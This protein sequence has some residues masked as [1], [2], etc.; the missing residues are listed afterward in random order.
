MRHDFDRGVSQRT[1]VNLDGQLMTIVEFQ[2]VKPGKG[3]A[4][5][6]TKFKNVLTG[7]VI[8]KTFRSGERWKTC[9]SKNDTSTTTATSTI[10]WTRVLR[11]NPVGEAVG[12]NAKWFKE[13]MMINLVFRR[14]SHHGQRSDFGRAEDYEMRSGVQGDRYRRHQTGHA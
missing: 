13:N 12:D 8:E 10:S 6:R 7:R 5:V 11:T 1:V 9:A 14:K 2:H 4:F 3:G